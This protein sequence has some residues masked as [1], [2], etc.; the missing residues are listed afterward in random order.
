MVRFAFAMGLSIIA[1]STRSLPRCAAPIR[2]RYA[3]RIGAH[4]RAFDTCAVILGILA[5]TPTAGWGQTETRYA[6]EPTTGL[7]LP[8]IGLA[9]EHDAFS[10]SMN[11]AGLRFLR[12]LHLG[13]AVDLTDDD[14]ATQAGQGVGLYLGSRFGGR[15]LPR[16]G[17]GASVEFG[18]PPRAVLSPDLGTPTRVSL[19][20]AL[21]LGKSAGLGV[22]RHWLFDAPG[23]I[24][25]G[26]ATWDLGISMRLGQRFALGAVVRDLSA[27]AAAGQ[28]IERRYELELLSRPLATDRLE[29]TLGGRISEQSADLDG[30]FRLSARVVQGLY[31]RGE[32]HSRDLRVLDTTPMGTSESNERELLAS[33]GIEI[34]FGA[35]GAAFWGTGARNAAG[36]NRLSGGTV[37]A[38]VSSDRIPSI[39]PS[40]K[41]IEKLKLQGA[42]DQR[43]ITSLVLQLRAIARDDDVVALVIAIDDLGVGWATVQELWV[44]LSRV[45]ESGKRVFAYVI[46]ASTR[47]YFL[48]TAADK[49]YLDPAGGIRL[50][51][52]AAS[53]LFFKGLFDK[54]G[55]TAQFIKVDEYKSAPETYTRASPTEPAWRMREQVY[56]DIYRYIV[57][58]IASRRN[59][60]A[61]TVK[62]FIDAGPY[63]AGDLDNHPLIDAVATPDEVGKLVVAD[64]GAAYQVGTRSRTRPDRWSLPKIAVIYLDG[65][66]VGGESQSVPLI[67]R[68]LVGGETIVQAIAQA[69]A[70]DDVKAI[71]LRIDSPGGSALASEMMAREVF[72]TRGVKPI[73]CSMGD[74]AAS[75]G[76]FA[77]AGCDEIFAQPTTITGS[78]GIF[79]GKFDLSGLLGRLGMS[80]TTHKR[81]QRA[82]MDTYFRPYSD[83]EKTV[84]LDK[85][86]YL[87]G[88]FIGA[89]AEGRSMTK[90]QV[91]DVARGR[92]WS[93]MAAKRERLVDRMG[94][95]GDAIARAKQLAGYSDRQR[96]RVIALPARQAGLLDLVL[97]SSGAMERGP[98]AGATLLFPGDRTVLD[99]LPGS[100]WREPGAPQARL[101]FSIVWH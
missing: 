51:G 82:D 99:K 13:S 83:E 100:V 87:Y 8:G 98:G 27:P 89:V 18:R 55:V 30:W 20:F 101:P 70:D 22:A 43:A 54:L 37:L 14:T 36:D 74:V 56:D 9:G 6:E 41:R 79:T 19:A 38:R 45:R 92:V 40:G 48:A 96:V 97:G 95:I 46:A 1:R 61:A 17:F 93:G 47:D 71:V 52:M 31:V 53:T 59:I 78:I 24:A 44:E 75:G 5:L 35:L 60:D 39:V 77:A 11:P 34:S 26:L 91:D 15:L 68:K 57:Q 65:D 21:P 3:P 80:W 28:S 90:K 64:L 86:T 33:V 29:L 62:R 23:S 4:R 76:Y 69:R 42:Y 7:H 2:C 67:G 72:K 12:G 49:V 10:V 94:G 81:G 88:R 16:F 58:G 84:I 50:I 63:T 66:I 32:L 73:L 25:D 85:I